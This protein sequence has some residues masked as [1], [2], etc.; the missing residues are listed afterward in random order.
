MAEPTTT[1]SSHRVRLPVRSPWFSA[2]SVAHGITWIRE[3]GVHPF[4]RAN[5]WHVPGS[6]R[7]LLV[8]AGMGIASLRTSFPDLM[9]DRTVLFV[10]HGHLDH[11]GGAH[12]F[13]ERYCHVDEVG[14]LADPED[15]TL[16]TA[17]LDDA[18][19]SAL[20]ADSPE[21][22]PPPYLVDSVPDESYDVHGYAMTPAPPS[23]TFEDGEVI[24]LGDRCFEV[25]HL[26][27]HT[28]GSTVLF[29]Q[30]TGVLF[31]GDVLYEGELLDELPESD[32]DSYVASMQR[33]LDLDVSIAL[34]GHEDPLSTADVQRLG[35]AYLTKRAR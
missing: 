21:G 26:P 15:E 30:T 27:G 29:E 14:M 19:A 28:P 9:T 32:I 2:E 35:T 8:D 5:M 1:R 17:E 16:V 4:L 13:P 25:I 20:A 12:E 3:P 34:P 18:F 7:D 22:Q 24:D 11:A 31:T 6:E 10:T 33:L 23:H